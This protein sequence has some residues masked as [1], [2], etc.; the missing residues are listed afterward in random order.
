MLIKERYFV[1]F[2]KDF[3]SSC[4]ILYHFCTILLRLHMNPDMHI[5]PTGTLLA[6]MDFDDTCPFGVS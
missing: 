2:L 5:G 3:D 4:R 6:V 1:Y